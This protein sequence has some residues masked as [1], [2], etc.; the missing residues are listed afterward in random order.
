[1]PGTN[2]L[3]Y[4]ESPQITDR[5]SFMTLVP[6]GDPDSARAEENAPAEGLDQQLHSSS[7]ESELAG[8][9]VDGDGSASVRQRPCVQVRRSG[10]SG[11]GQRRDAALRQPG[12]DGGHKHVFLADTSGKI[13]SRTS[14]RGAFPAR[15]QSYKK[16]CVHNL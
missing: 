2:T 16:F 10:Q 12:G 15:T 3:A 1:M 5:K 9:S 4:Y 13:S 14:P 11:D 7:V 6:E 8:V